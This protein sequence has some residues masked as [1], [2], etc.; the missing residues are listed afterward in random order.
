MPRHVTGRQERELWR[1]HRWKEAERGSVGHARRG[2]FADSKFGRIR[3]RVIRLFLTQCDQVITISIHSKGTRDEQARAECTR[4][5]IFQAEV[6]W[7]V[8]HRASRP[9]FFRP[10]LRLFRRR[11]PKSRRHLGSWEWW[12]AAVCAHTVATRAPSGIIFGQSS[13][14]GNRLVTLRRLPISCQLVGN[15]TNQKATRIGR[16]GCSVTL[17][18]HQS[19]EASRTSKSV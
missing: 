6:A 16:S 9:H 4:T 19:G 8:A 18:D 12:R 15:A 13:R 10:S 2:G 11:T 14:A 1:G 5:L 3:K 17:P 7:T